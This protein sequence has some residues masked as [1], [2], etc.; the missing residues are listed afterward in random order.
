MKIDT[1]RKIFKRDFGNYTFHSPRVDTCH[2][3]D[4]LK[5][6]TLSSKPGEARTHQMTLKH[7]H[8]KANEARTA[9]EMDRL[10][11]S[12]ITENKTCI[13]IDLQQVLPIP[14]LTHSDMYYSRQLSYYNFGIHMH[15]GNECFMNLWNET[16]G[17]RG[18][19]EIASCIF[20]LLNDKN[21]PIKTR[22]LIVWSDN[23]GGQNKNKIILFM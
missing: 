18:A 21:S 5:M 11:C 9:M 16:E 14:T 6:L 12:L 3:C 20:N 13:S 7:Q 23:C 22:K 8:D 2:T 10:N 4:K 17:G 1:Y 19:S 15:P